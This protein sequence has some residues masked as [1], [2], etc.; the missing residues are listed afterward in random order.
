MS[1]KLYI[2][3]FTVF[4]I[5][6]IPNLKEVSKSKLDTVKKN[7]IIN[8]EKIKIIIARKYL[9]IS[10]SLALILFRDNLLEYI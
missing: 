1:D 2:S 3:E 10:F 4:I 6:R 8:K 9:F 7:V 5:V